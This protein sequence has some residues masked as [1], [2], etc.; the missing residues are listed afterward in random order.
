MGHHNHEFTTQP[1]QTE[2][3][4]SQDLPK[5]TG[6]K[7]SQAKGRSRQQNPC[8]SPLPAPEPCRGTWCG[9]SSNGV[10]SQLRVSVQDRS[11]CLELAWAGVCPFGFAFPLAEGAIPFPARV[12][13]G[14]ERGT[15]TAA[16]LQQGWDT[17]GHGEP[18]GRMEE[19]KV[20][21]RRGGA[22]ELPSAPD[23]TGT[24]G[25]SGRGRGAA[26]EGGGAAQAPA[27]ARVNLSEVRRGWEPWREDSQT[28]SF[29]L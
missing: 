16:G 2:E 22:A 19:P 28:D 27:P 25:R 6:M 4:Q 23:H 3:K 5:G 10:H 20:G 9:G 1:P 17:G 26:G 14:R 7:R 29:Q 8:P 12:P 24:T 15:G 21:W 18:D 13:R 11:R